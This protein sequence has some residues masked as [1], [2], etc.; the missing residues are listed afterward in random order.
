[1]ALLWKRKKKRQRENYFPLGEKNPRT[2]ITL[3]GTRS[4]YL[5]GHP[6]LWNL[7]SLT[8]KKK[9]KYSLDI[10]LSSVDWANR[11]TFISNMHGGLWTQFIPLCTCTVALWEIASLSIKMCRKNDDNSVPF[12]THRTSVCDWDPT[13]AQR[14]KKKWNWFEEISSSGTNSSGIS[15]AEGIKG[16]GWGPNWQWNTQITILINTEP[17]LTKKKYTHTH[18]KIQLK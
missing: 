8:G 1:M 18:K 3:K 9:D 2:L 5:W 16:T 14:E 12:A 13:Y 17:Y 7:F 15:E 10:L 11:D 6:L 4:T